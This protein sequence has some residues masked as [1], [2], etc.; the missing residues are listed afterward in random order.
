[1]NRDILFL[2][3]IL[4]SIRC[5]DIGLKCCLPGGDTDR[6]VD[7]EELPEYYEEVTLPFCNIYWFSLECKIVFNFPFLLPINISPEQKSKAESFRG[8][9]NTKCSE[10]VVLDFCRE[11][12]N[13]KQILGDS[14]SAP[15]YL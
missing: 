15:T 12:S 13:G 2:T 8:I 10:A 9:L 1:M 5:Q 14:A 3:L 4:I 11:I 7:L 6:E